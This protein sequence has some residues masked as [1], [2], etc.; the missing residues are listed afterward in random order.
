MKTI[1]TYIS[2]KLK[3]NKDSKL[4]ITDDEA[5]ELAENILKAIDPLE[6]N[7]WY[8]GL[9]EAIAD[10]IYDND[11]SDMSELRILAD[12]NKVPYHKYLRQLTKSERILSTK[13]IKQKDATFS[14]WYYDFW[15][16]DRFILCMNTKNGQIYIIRK[17]ETS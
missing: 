8:I 13:I 10:W 9:Q 3:L 11:I 7:D 14:D 4:N 2:E 17:G 16:L 6:V 1:D 15:I 12:M 5:N